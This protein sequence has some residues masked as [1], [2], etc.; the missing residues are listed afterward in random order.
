MADGIIM[1]RL[2][3]APEIECFG[4]HL[5]SISDEENLYDAL[6]TS[7]DSFDIV[8]LLLEINSHYVNVEEFVENV[9]LSLVKV[10]LEAYPDAG[11]E[12]GRRLIVGPSSPL[13]ASVLEDLSQDFSNIEFIDKFCA[14]VEINGREILSVDNFKPMTGDLC[15]ILTCNTEASASYEASF[16]TGN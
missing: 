5:Q 10:C 3:L 6:G 1:K 16:G 8:D 4:Q 14:G 2:D 12:N 9:N 7:R 15:L 11:Q 13:F